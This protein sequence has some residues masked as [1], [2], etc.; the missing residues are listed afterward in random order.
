[1]G[2][3]LILY[4]IL[5]S[6]LL[7]LLLPAFWIY[8]RMTGRHAKHFKERLG[9][10]PSHVIQNLS[11]HP[12]IWIHAVSLGE[13][14]VAA[15]IINALMNVRP[16]CSIILSTI[17]ESGRGM[18]EETFGQEI[19]VIF[20]PI[21][22]VGS[23]R[24]ALSTIRPDVMVFLETE[25]WPIWVNQAHLMGIRTA[26]INGR[27]STK[28]IGGYLRLRFFFR[29][30][31][32]NFDAFS[33]IM[34]G[35]ADR[36]E[37]MGAE[38]HKIEINGNAKYDLLASTVDL[39]AETEIRRILNFGPHERVFVAGSTRNG[40]EEMILDAYEK[41]LK[42]FPG[43]I[44]VIVP[45]HIERTPDIGSMIVRR[46]FE[47]QLRT[48]F[49][50]EKAKRTKQI[51]IINTFGELF[52]IYGIGTI[53]FSGGSLV[54]LGGQNPLEPA[55]WGKVVFYGP[56]MDN[57]LDATALLEAVNAGVTVENSKVLADK[58]IWFMNHPEELKAYGERAREAVLENEGASEK[59]ARVIERLLS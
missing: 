9:L 19:P 46:G 29:G 44:L 7:V 18:A 30:V 10:V 48:D 58:A 12:R 28:S 2:I 38:S 3:L 37:S 43:T 32:R 27:I 41:I 17:T 25:I 55:I 5:T 39:S 23:V 15:S 31:L 4:T 50:N 1:M 45:R 33:M 26:L 53:V 51:I 14:K 24:N 13:I 54:P 42:E 8:T 34:E 40:E 59:H 56:H 36:I 47:Y 57:F 20:A 21:D 35:D 49:S 22:F 11:G 16:N 6:M 52:N